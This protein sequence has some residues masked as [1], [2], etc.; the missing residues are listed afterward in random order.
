[1]FFPLNPGE[2]WVGPP[3]CSVVPPAIQLTGVMIEEN[4]CCIEM[5]DNLK[6]VANAETYVNGQLVTPAGVVLHH[7]DRIIIGGTHYFH[8]HNPADCQTPNRHSNIK[9][10]S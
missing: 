4:H 3:I 1:M 10:S 8:L 7:G 2:N 9:V 5:A 6:L